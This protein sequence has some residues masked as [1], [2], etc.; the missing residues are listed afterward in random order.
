MAPCGS[1]GKPN[2][3]FGATARIGFY[4]VIAPE[5]VPV[6]PRPT[7][8]PDEMSTCRAD[9]GPSSVVLVAR[10]FGEAVLEVRRHADLALAGIG[11][12]EV[13][14]LVPVEMVERVRVHRVRLGQL[15]GEHADL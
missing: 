2:T 9:A 7:A 14:R 4:D 3:A 5:L 10:A 15:A 6:L 1:D 12:R 13:G 11:L 8:G